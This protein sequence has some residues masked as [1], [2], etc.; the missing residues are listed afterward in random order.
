MHKCERAAD[1]SHVL[2]E[3]RSSFNKVWLSELTPATRKCW[4]RT[5][6]HSDATQRPKWRPGENLLQ[7]L[8][9]KELE[10]SCLTWQAHSRKI[11]LRSVRNVCRNSQ[12][13][14][15]TP[16]NSCWRR[17]E[18]PEAENKSIW[19]WWRRPRRRSP[20]WRHH[21]LKELGFLDGL[22]ICV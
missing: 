22:V 21:L 4:M 15:R 20:S 5:A 1:K 13:M 10:E 12:T 17:R 2:G 7:C 9:V 11:S 16:G 19:R 8:S 14:R 6:A 18:S 3:G